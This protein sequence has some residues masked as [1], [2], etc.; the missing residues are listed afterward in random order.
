VKLDFDNSF[1]LTAERGTALRNGDQ[2]I[3]WDIQNERCPV[4]RS[5]RSGAGPAQILQEGNTRTVFFVI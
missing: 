5:S 3:R 4:S 1:R 2:P